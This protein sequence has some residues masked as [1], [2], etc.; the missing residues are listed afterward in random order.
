MVRALL[1]QM[2][3]EPCSW[4]TGWQHKAASRVERNHREHTLM[5]VLSD[6]E[7]ALLR[8]QSGSFRLFAPANVAAN[9]IP[10]AIIVQRVRSQGCWPDGDMLWRMQWPECAARQA[11][12][13]PQT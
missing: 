5:P 1:L 6:S 4:R 8:S 12:G 13:F 9:S 3:F 10:L 7:K 2:G 11:N